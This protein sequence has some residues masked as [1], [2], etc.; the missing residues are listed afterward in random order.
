MRESNHQLSFRVSAGLKNLIGRDLISDKNVA[1]FELVKNSYDA[2]ATSV[3]IEFV[4]TEKDE[5]KIIISDNGIGMSYD[6]IIQKWLFVAFSDKKE[7]N[8]TEDNA[9]RDEIRREVAGAK[10]VGRFSCDRL[11]SLLQLL[12]KTQNDDVAHIIN[13]NWSNFE[14]DDT[15]E[16]I[17]VPVDYTTG[18]DLPSG[19]VRGTTLIVSCLREKWNREDILKLKRSLMKLISPD[20]SLSETPFKIEI[21]A[22]DET[23]EDKNEKKKSGNRDRN[24]VNGLVNNDI[25]EKL[26][27]K[28]TNIDVTISVDGKQIV[29]KLSDRGQYIFTVTEKNRAYSLLKNINISVFYLNRSA[30]VSFTRQMGGVEPKNYGSIFIY[31]NGFRI[32]PFGEPGQDF[33]NINTR[34]AQGYARFLGTRELMGRISI[35][36]ND[37]QFI[38]TTSRAHGFINTPEVEMLGTFFL[39]KVL[40]VL[41][42]YV[43]N[44]ISWG[45]P[46]KTDPNQQTIDP[47]EVGEQIISQFI[48][49]V[50]PQDIISLDYNKELID[51]NSSLRQV[52][53]IIS[54][55]EKLTSV[56]EAT[57]DEGL[58]G[59]AKRVKSRTEKVL[60]E[61]IQLEEE[62]KAKERE[63]SKAKLESAKR[64]KQVFFLKGA[65]NQS[66][67]NLINGLHTVYTLTDAIKGNLEYLRNI[68]DEIDIRRKDEILM[69]LG[70]IF[71]SNEKAHKLAELAI[72]GSQNLKLSGKN[73]IL[74]YIRQY[75]DVGLVVKGLQYHLVATEDEAYDCMFDAPSMGVIL[76]NI[77]SN[78]IKA[79]ATRLDISLTGLPKSVEIQF[80]DDGVG[81]S[82]DINPDLLF[83]W[84][85]SSNAID[86]GFG[87]GLYHIKTLVSE[88]KGEV[89]I[90]NK[91]KNGFRL[92]VSLRK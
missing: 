25:F 61:N 60:A 76:D 17:E 12:T 57:Q 69:I 66:V 28:T 35:K 9:Y 72:N 5:G 47:R 68:F 37:E 42:K 62:T 2:G 73:S 3:T 16:F 22:L 24:I 90:D 7:K 86:K 21:I 67:E 78:S 75:I 91:Y 33:L 23:T 38:E 41:E 71:Q 59:L 88:M 19:F 85:V 43:V 39:E 80:T 52:D 49:N 15:R 83:E 56:A 58:I 18:K 74:D 26:N 55:L 84:G 70:D 63:L 89:Y 14:Y 30:K 10:G 81:L 53:S 44:I 65:T 64:E 46:L 1:I 79:R 6:D 8:R 50:N 87:I 34:K 13:V 29:S 48:A 92:V 31:K 45:E 20:V 36:G 4:K 32:N 27:L 51:E 82:D 77:I 11:G 40:K 54:S